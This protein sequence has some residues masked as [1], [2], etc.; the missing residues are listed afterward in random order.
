MAQM[1]HEVAGVVSEE[2]II[3]TDQ[4]VLVELAAEAS[5]ME[6]SRAVHGLFHCGGQSMA[7][8]SLVAKK[9]LI[10][11]IV[12]E[13]EISREKQK[14]M[15]WEHCRIRDEQQECQQQMM[16]IL[17]KVSDQVKKVENI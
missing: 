13:Q 6:V 11:K 17:E 4:G 8:D 10:T 12:R 3:L 14:E 2:L 9:D 16:E 1:L 5:I 7:V 15:E